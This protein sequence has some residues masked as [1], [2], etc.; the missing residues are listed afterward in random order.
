MRGCLLA[1]NLTDDVHAILGLM[2]FLV[3]LAF[4]RD[5]SQQGEGDEGKNILGNA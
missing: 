2:V 5:G 4:Q 1:A 3:A